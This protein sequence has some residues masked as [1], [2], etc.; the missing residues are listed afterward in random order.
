MQKHSTGAVE[1]LRPLGACEEFFYLIDENSPAHFVLAAEIY[2][3]V[4]IKAWRLALDR[5]QQRHPLWSVHIK[6]NAEGMPCFI[7]DPERP[8]SLR[9]VRGSRSLET[10]KSEFDRELFTRFYP[11]AAPLVRATLIV[12]RC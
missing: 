5:V 3:Q 4:D 6:R 8:V 1:I 12:E 10:W 11:E 9:I 2:G 7:R